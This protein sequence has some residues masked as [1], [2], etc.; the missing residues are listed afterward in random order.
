MSGEGVAAFTGFVKGITM[1]VQTTK[2]LAAAVEFTHATLTNAF[3]MWMD[4]VARAAPNEYQHVYEWPSDFE[5]YD[6]TVGNP[7]FRLWKHMLVG[8]GRNRNAT[9]A[10]LP[11][12][13]PSPVDPILTSPG[14][15]GKVVKEGVHIFHWKA[16]AMEYGIEIEVTPKLSR[17]LAYVADGTKPESETGADYGF[18]G[19]N[20][21]QVGFSEGPVRFTAG[22]GQF[23]GKFTS[24]FMFWWA[25]QAAEAFDTAVRPT[26]EKNIVPRDKMGRFIAKGNRKG[27]KEFGGKLKS[28][29]IGAQSAASQK[30]FREALNAARRDLEGKANNYI[31]EARVRRMMIYGY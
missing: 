19:A 2:H 8:Q 26:L 24:A 22:G 13:R 25:S 18:Q 6:E 27:A 12:V 28:F 16:P 21:H 30:L 7:A 23:V 10:F 3:D 11:S 29:S 9:F 15:K 14:N 31:E 1:E 5:E 4:A 20:Q 17:Y